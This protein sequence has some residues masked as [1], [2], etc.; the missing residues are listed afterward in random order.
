M[1]KA[2]WNT[3]KKALKNAKR[4]AS[5][6]K[7]RGRGN[8]PY[9]KEKREKGH[10]TRTIKKEEG[11]GGKRKNFKKTRSIQA[12]RGLQETKGSNQHQKVLIERNF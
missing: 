3:R 7:K 2:W 6:G 5:T 11:G 9:H 1:A 12:R 8:K 10:N 4:S